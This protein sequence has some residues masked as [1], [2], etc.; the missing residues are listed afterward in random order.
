M[1]TGISH[2]TNGII[3]GVSSTLAILVLQSVV[4]WCRKEHEESG[5]ERVTAKSRPMMN[6]SARSNER[7]PSALSSTASESPEKTRH[8]NQRPLS[9]QAEKYDRTE[10]P[11]VNA[12]HTD[13][14][15]IENDETISHT[16]AESELSLGSRSFLHR[17]SDQA[18]KRQKQSSIH[19]TEDS[20][21]LSVI[22]GMLMSSTVQASF[23][24]VKNFSD[25][26]H[27]IKIQKISQWNIFSYVRN[28]CSKDQMRSMEWKQVTWKT[29]HGSTC[30]DW[31]WTSHQSLAHK[32]LSVFRFSIVSWKDEER[33]G[34]KVYRNTEPWIELMVSHMNSIGISSQDSSRC[35]SATKSKSHCQDWAH[36]Q[37]NLLDGSSSCRC[38]TTSQGD[39]W[40]TRKNAS[41]ML[42][43]FIYFQQ[44]LEQDNG[45]SLGLDLRRWSSTSEDSPQCEW[46]RVAEKMMLTFA[47]NGHPVFRAT[48]PLSRGVL[49]SKG[50]GKLSIHNCA[51]VETIEIVFRTIISVKQLSLYGA[52]AEMCKECES[53]HTFEWLSCTRTISIA[54]I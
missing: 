26:W 38:S 19:A 44:D 7:T 51:Y 52:V 53:C 45:D 39:Q 14:F 32:G 2:V 25:N 13:Q 21:E 28:W 33:S 11:V 27:S 30:L 5:E 35:S 54:K 17:V 22:W 34:S 18:R 37:G 47:E 24:M 43:S 41:Q 48:S 50:G 40:T 6:L 20:E 31:C 16:E 3:F 12:Q 4:K 15:I 23:L 8:E 1:L 49:K 10:R 42:N 36:H 9:S 29:L 46:D